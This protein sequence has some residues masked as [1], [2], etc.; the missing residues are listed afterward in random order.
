MG[1]LQKLASVLGLVCATL[2]F[3][4]DSAHD[5][6]AQAIQLRVEQL[7]A[8]DYR[9]RQDATRAI[10]S[11]GADALP[12]LRKA[13]SHPDAEIRRRLDELIQKL[14]RDLALAPR[15]VTLH[16]SKKPLKE[17]LA[18][19]AKQT[20]Y[21]IP[22]SD[23]QFK[24][25][26]ARAV[27]SFDF[28]KV[29][30]WEAM[31]RICE[32]SGMLLQQSNDE[33]LRFNFQ[34]NYVP[35]RSYDGIFKVTATGFNYYLNSNFG[36]LPR[37]P[38]QPA[39]QT[40]ESLQA[41]FMIAAEPRMPILRVGMPRLLKALDSE[42]HSMLLVEASAVNQPWMGRGYSGNMRT[43][44]QS[45]SANLAWPSKSSR[46]VKLLKGVIPVTLLVEQKPTVVTDQLT[47]AK[48]K[49]FKLGT[50]TFQVDDVTKRNASN[51]EFKLSYNDDNTEH[52]WD[53]SNIYSLQ[54]RLEVQDAKGLKC[55][56]Y[57]RWTTFNSPT[58]AQF[59]LTTQPPG[60][61]KAGTPAKLVYQL[62]VQ[63]EQ[64][65]EFEFKDLPL[66]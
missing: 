30:F 37:N 17:I 8:Q 3:A 20:G 2:A 57:I 38:V 13:R 50:S 39:Q 5:A 61:N 16:V 34:D 42:Q 14:E 49:K 24:S 40:Y 15:R 27:Y 10:L 48:G 65:V 35:Y 1:R 43:Y 55:N 26:A 6:L 7:G 64:D 44:V 21:K 22:S 32:A 25:A 33:V 4:S 12:T 47:S 56:S 46:T 60:V 41:N 66:P 36:Q 58:S 63:M 52:N 53:Y 19:L 59:V 29:T 51:Y 23:A 31:D 9:T 28:D 45:A 54:Q 11:M 62:W 18:L